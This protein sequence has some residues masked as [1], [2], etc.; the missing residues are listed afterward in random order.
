MPYAWSL[1]QVDIRHGGLVDSGISGGL[2]PCC[3]SVLLANPIMAPD[4]RKPGQTLTPW[5]FPFLG[6]KCL[7]WQP[8]QVELP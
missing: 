1:Q 5:S 8:V 2:M 7:H 4:I 3:A 6:S